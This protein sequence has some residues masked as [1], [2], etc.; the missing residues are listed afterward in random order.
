MGLSPLLLFPPPKTS[1][2]RTAP[3]SPDGLNVL[4]GDGPVLVTNRRP[5]LPGRVAGEA[6]R[7]SWWAAFQTL[8]ATVYSK[9]QRRHVLAALQAVRWGRLH[10]RLMSRPNSRVSVQSPAT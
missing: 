2:L 4:T 5:R 3:P 6:R 10:Q 7:N 8:P 9:V 1:V